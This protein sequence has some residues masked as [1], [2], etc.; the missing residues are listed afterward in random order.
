MPA[1][2]QRHGPSGQNCSARGPDS[3]PSGPRSTALSSP[4]PRRAAPPCCPAVLP[5]RA[6]PPCCPAV[7]PRRAAPPCCP[8]VLPGSVPAPIRAVTSFSTVSRAHLRRAGPDGPAR[9]QREA[10]AS[11]E[12]E[13]AARVTRRRWLRFTLGTRRCGAAALPRPSDASPTARRRLRTA[14]PVTRPP[15]APPYLAAAPASITTRPSASRCCA[16]RR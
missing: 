11:S 7:L 2:H 8:A 1:C 14:P 16:D 6:A 4:L 15:A 13:S 9:E 5:R 10:D 12:R 3:A